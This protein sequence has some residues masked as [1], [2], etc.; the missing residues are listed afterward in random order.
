MTFLVLFK[1]KPY[2]ICSESFLPHRMESNATC[3][4]CEWTDELSNTTTDLLSLTINHM[5][6]F[7]SLLLLEKYA[8]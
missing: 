2:L 6:I 1:H 7:C 8:N 5:Q 4:V 3:S